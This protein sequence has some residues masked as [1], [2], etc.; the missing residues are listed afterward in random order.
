MNT[1]TW[2][3]YRCA[4]EPN[5]ELFE[6]SGVVCFR[7][8]LQPADVDLIASEIDDY[9]QN[10]VPNLH[11]RMMTYEQT[12]TRVIRS[13]FWLNS[14]SEF[15]REL[16]CD[17]RLIGAVSSLVDWD[18]VLHYVEYFAKPPRI[19]APLAMHQ[20]APA[21]F[22]DRADLV[23]IWIAIDHANAANGGVHFYPGSHRL[24]ELPHKYGEDSYLILDDPEQFADWEPICFDLAPGDGTVHTAR[25]VHY[26][27]PNQSANRR[28]G[29]G[30]AYRSAAA[31]IDR[32]RAQDHIGFPWPE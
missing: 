13:L 4:V 5:R 1:T 10:V 23:A 24:G 6:E 27:G 17:R 11:P 20:D 32:V 21:V 12:S 28:R 3:C 18:P 14:H 7:N 16:P 2:T 19:G 15:F 31:T 26:S 25:T 30:I 29:I 9:L 8:L 22:L